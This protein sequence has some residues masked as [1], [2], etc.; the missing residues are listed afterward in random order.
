MFRRERPARRNCPLMSA[1][2]ATANSQKGMHLSRWRQTMRERRWDVIMELLHSQQGLPHKNLL[3]FYLQAHFV[4]L[5]KRKDDA[6]LNNVYCK[7]LLLFPIQ[8][9]DT[10][11]QF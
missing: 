11:T 4:Y 3:C 2:S 1:I 7:L 6:S 10:H 5:S 8:T 9:K